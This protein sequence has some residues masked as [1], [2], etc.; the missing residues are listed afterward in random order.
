[1]VYS[2]AVA[3]YFAADNASGIGVLRGAPNLANMM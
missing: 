1:V 2:F 3:G